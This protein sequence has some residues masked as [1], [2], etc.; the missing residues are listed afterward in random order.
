MYTI[1]T[2]GYS[3]GLHDRETKHAVTQGQTKEMARSVTVN[4]RG[5]ESQSARNSAERL[6]SA[7]VEHMLTWMWIGCM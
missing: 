2:L 6:V 4:V 3:S 7:Y 1:S 5:D